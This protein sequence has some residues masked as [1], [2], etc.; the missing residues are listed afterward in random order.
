MPIPGRKLMNGSELIKLNEWSL[1]LVI[2]S[3][4]IK[5]NNQKERQFMDNTEGKLNE[6]MN[7]V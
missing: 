1:G 7:I 2:Y 6:R 3:L 4:L 5:S